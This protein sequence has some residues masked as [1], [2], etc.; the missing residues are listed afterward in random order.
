MS[1]A[2][3][4]A[5]A[6][7]FEAP[8]EPPIGQ[9]ATGWVVVNSAT[10]HSVCDEVFSGRYVG[11]NKGIRKS[12]LRGARWD[13]CLLM[14]TKIVGGKV[15]DPTHGA[16]AFECTRWKSCKQHPWWARHMKYAGKF[17]SQKFWRSR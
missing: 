14:A 6:L 3:C 7:Y 15:S 13:K 10:H 9:A 11:V 12:P 1:A 4:L 8:G 5:I 2:F 16:T 17:G